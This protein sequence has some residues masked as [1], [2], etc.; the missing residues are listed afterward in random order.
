MSDFIFNYI[1]SLEEINKIKDS[2]VF[3]IGNLNE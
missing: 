3:P 2:K 1:R